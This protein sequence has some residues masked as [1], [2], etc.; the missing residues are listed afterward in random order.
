M[1][2]VVTPK[3]DTDEVLPGE[4]SEED[5]EVVVGGLQSWPTDPDGQALPTDAGLEPRR[6]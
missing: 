5:L 6:S 3:T 2:R 4:L 1:E